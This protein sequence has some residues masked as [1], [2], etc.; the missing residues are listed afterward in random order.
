MFKKNTKNQQPALNSAASELSEK[1]R[2]RLESSWAGTFDK[3]FFSRINEETFSVL[4]LDLPSRP[5]VPIN[6]LVGLKALKAGFG[7]SDAEL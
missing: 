5:N 3:E 2:E 1:Q 4:Y 7:W 6:V